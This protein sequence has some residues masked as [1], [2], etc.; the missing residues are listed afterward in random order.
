[1]PVI[2]IVSDVSELSAKP[3]HPP[4]TPAT[5]VQI[6][7]GT[8][9]RILRPS[10]TLT[11]FFCCRRER[12][13]SWKFYPEFVEGPGIASGT[14]G[15]ELVLSEAE[16][17]PLGDANWNIRSSVKLAAFFV[18]GVEGRCLGHFILSLSKGLT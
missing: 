8:P 16:G 10:I 12:P 4:F 7:L 18:V 6:P 11:A 17:N 5:G 3:C 9:I 14:T 1:V 15:G 13:L 2:I